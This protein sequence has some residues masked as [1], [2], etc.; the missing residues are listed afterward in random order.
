M[1]KDKMKNI[2]FFLK[3]LWPFSTLLRIKYGGETMEKAKLRRLFD[4][5]KFEG[6]QALKF[7]IEST[8]SML[9]EKSD[10]EEL[11]YEQLEMLSA[12]GIVE[13]ELPKNKE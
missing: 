13:S 3:K 5:Q 12:A 7:A 2:S 11:S 10:K 8:R 4:F 9:N 6:N 1:K